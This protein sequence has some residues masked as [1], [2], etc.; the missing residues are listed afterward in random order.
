VY[1]C[2]YATV[3]LYTLTR[4]RIIGGMVASTVRVKNEKATKNNTATLPPAIDDNLREKQGNSKIM[5]VI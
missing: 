3:P 1:F 4:E 2:T 5:R